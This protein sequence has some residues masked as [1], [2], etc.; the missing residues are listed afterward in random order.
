MERTRVESVTM[1][2]DGWQS[3]VKALAESQ[4]ELSERVAQLSADV[5]AQSVLLSQ[6]PAR[7]AEARLRANASSETG[8]EHDPEP[9]KM[10]FEEFANEVG[11]RF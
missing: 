9:P 10:T 3:A 8:N 5:R 2:N 7:Q 11:L 4:K 1:E 6:S